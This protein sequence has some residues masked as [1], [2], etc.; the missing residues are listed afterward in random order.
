MLVAIM[1]S[2]NTIYVVARYLKNEPI[3]HQQ[4]EIDGHDYY[5]SSRVFQRLLDR[6][7][8]LSVDEEGAVAVHRLSV[9]SGSLKERQKA[10]ETAVTKTKRNELRN[11]K[12]KGEERAPGGFIIDYIIP[13]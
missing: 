3:V 8:L 2:E 5:L 13:R 11:F 1:E 6:V 9:R 7:L 12:Q 10:K 4:Q